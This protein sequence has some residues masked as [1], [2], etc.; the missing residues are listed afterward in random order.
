MG[1]TKRIT[2]QDAPRVA[3]TFEYMYK[4]NLLPKSLEGFTRSKSKIGW[5]LIELMSKTNIYWIR[6]DK[7]KHY[8]GPIVKFGDIYKHM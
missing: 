8:N 2:K 6:W 3:R 4:T 1:N 7:K 5:E